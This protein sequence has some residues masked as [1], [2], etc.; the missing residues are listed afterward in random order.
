MLPHG[1]DANR[2]N[3]EVAIECA[4]KQNMIP[5]KYEVEELFE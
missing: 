5:R 4:W 2:R 3:L 1:L